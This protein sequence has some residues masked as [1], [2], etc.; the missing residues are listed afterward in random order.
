MGNTIYSK[1]NIERLLALELKYMK[2]GML[3][4]EKE[5]LQKEMYYIKGMGREKY[6][7]MIIIM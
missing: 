7:Q 1:N 6:L 2:G 5:Y 4:E 3:I